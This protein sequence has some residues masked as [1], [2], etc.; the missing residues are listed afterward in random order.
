MTES[1]DSTEPHASEPRGGDDIEARRW[2]ADWCTAAEAAYLAEAH[3]S[4][5]HDLRDSDLPEPPL[6]KLLGYDF[7]DWPVTGLFGADDDPRAAEARREERRRAVFADLDRQSEARAREFRERQAAER[8]RSVPQT[9]PSDA[10]R[11]PGRAAARKPRVRPL[12]GLRTKA[13]AAAKLG[14]SIKTLNGHVE[15]GALGY[16]I[17]GHG[18]R[19]TRKMFADADLDAFIEAQTRKVTPCPSTRTGTAVRR[20]SISTSKSTVIGFMEARSKRR[21]AKPK[22]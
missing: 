8:Q 3:A 15:S 2:A 11:T 12:D 9:L 22:R 16:V 14:C 5:P 17:I 7:M 6:D 4:A 21:G 1:P 18:K 13:E 19:R 10:L 20:S